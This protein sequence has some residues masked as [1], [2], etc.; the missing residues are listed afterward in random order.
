M[1]KMHI[2]KSVDIKAP[3]QKVFAILNDFNHWR[4]WSPW[5]I[6]DPDASTTV[7]EDGKFNEWNGN[8]VGSGNMRIVSET[9]NETIDYDLTFLKPWKST[10]KVQFSLK[11]TEELT[12]VSWSM[13]SRLPFFM[14]WM[15]KMMEAMVGMDYQR[16]LNML[17]EYVEE[18]TV[19]SKLIFVGPNTHP[20]NDYVGIKTNSTMDLVGED[21]SSD[22][23]KL[24]H[25]FENQR[26]GIS[27]EPFSI[28]HNFGFVDKK[29]DYTCGVPVH[30]IPN[31]IPKDFVTGQIPAIKVY[32]L[33]HI[34]PYRH[35]GNAWTTLH[36][37][38]RNKE[39]KMNKGVQPFESY[40][41]DP[42]QV[43]ENELITDVQFPIY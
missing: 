11:L 22:L 4:A 39:F 41:N 18:D 10:A 40:M 13:D 6:Q 3:A 27:A 7:S 31:S 2:H 16:G 37:M 28:Y 43:H 21:M 35:L 29:V 15:K 25:F 38:N 42:S 23:S 9:A 26:E 33:R 30:K 32:T 24:W 12:N 17:K 34:G 1:A 5:M 19:H 20:G 8:R 14:F 36:T